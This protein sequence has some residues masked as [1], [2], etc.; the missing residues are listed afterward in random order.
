MSQSYS[1]QPLFTV[2]TRSVSSRLLPVLSTYLPTHAPCSH[3]PLQPSPTHPHHSRRLCKPGEVPAV[4]GRVYLIYERRLLLCFVRQ[5]QAGFA[6]VSPKPA[7]SRAKWWES[8]ASCLLL[9]MAHTIP[10]SFHR[11][12]QHLLPTVAL[13]CLRAPDMTPWWDFQ[14]HG[15]FTADILDVVC[16]TLLFK[17]EKWR[18]LVA[19]ED[20]WPFLA[21][22]L[23]KKSGELRQ[24]LINV[25][26]FGRRST[27][28]KF[29]AQ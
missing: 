9:H 28:R 26:F 1:G 5:P 27:I 20:C 25:D 12:R 10:S 6:L 3:L 8:E 14:T 7:R 29:H 15:W 19:R 18:D 21:T 4:S 22:T 11:A 16:V 24:L 13:R 23:D 17:K 2:F